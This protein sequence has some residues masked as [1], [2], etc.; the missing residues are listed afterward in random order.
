MWRSPSDPYCNSPKDLCILL[1]LSQPGAGTATLLLGDQAIVRGGVGGG[2]V[3][4]ERSVWCLLPQDRAGQG[5]C[6]E[7]G[8]TG[9]CADAPAGQVPPGPGKDQP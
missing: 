3:R 8:R 1:L 5:L 9:C 7:E 4:P 2:L 6:T